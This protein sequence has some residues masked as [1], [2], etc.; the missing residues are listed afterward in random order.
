MLTSRLEKYK[1]VTL[2]VVPEQG[3]LH[4]VWDATGHA[5]E[6]PVENDADVVRCTRIA[7]DALR[8]LAKVA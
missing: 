1:G 8:A 4:I 6:G 7:I 3:W 5:F 2:I